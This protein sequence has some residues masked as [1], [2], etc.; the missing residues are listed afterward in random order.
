MQ[1]RT[2]F[3]LIAA[4]VAINLGLAAANLS[5]GSPGVG[6]EQGWRSCQCYENGDPEGCCAV[7]ANSCN[8]CS[9]Q[10]NPVRP[11]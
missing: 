5:A 4:A 10:P 3:S 9:I 6:C 8:G 7:C 11:G 1:R 2:R